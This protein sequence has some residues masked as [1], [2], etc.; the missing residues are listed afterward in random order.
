[1]RQHGLLHAALAGL[2]ILAATLAGPAM[3]QG[4]RPLKLVALGDSLTAG[5]G[6]PAAA[7]FPTQLQQALKAR[8]HDVEIV[9]AG[10]SGDTAAGGLERLDW[11]VGEGVD[12]VILELGANDMLRGLDPAATKATL[13]TIVRRLKARN[14]PVLLTGM[15]AS[16]NLGPDYAAR[17]DAIYPDIARAH[18]V[19]L[20]PF[21]LDGVAGQ[22]NLNIADG[23][24][25]NP[26]GVRI[27]VER[28]LPTVET[29]IARL[30]PA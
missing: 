21:F 8:G 27:I 15:L 25:P 9:N 3:A 30:R 7:A 24:H 12:G 14:I 19:M 28:M 20:Y 13:D 18:G 6:L 4:K 22:R 26:E 1:M 17:F 5:Y 11:S 23:I 16:R 2:M 29:F 10:V